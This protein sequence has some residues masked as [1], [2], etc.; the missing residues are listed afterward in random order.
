MIPDTSNCMHAGITVIFGVVFPISLQGVHST[1]RYS[2]HGSMLVSSIPA[3]SS[4]DPV[5]VGD[6]ACW[7]VGALCRAM[8]DVSE[9][10]SFG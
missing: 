9:K 7:A 3:H 10:S 8:S 6:V 1:K 5:Q 4:W 2:P